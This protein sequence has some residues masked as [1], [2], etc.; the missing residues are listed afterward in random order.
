M[1]PRPA[2][3]H[4]NRR[5]RARR[6]LAIPVPRVRAGGQSSHSLRDSRP[7][8]NVTSPPL[9]ISALIRWCAGRERS[10]DWGNVST[11]GDPSAAQP[12]PPG[13]AELLRQNGS[14]GER[15]PAQLSPIA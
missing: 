12:L 15:L 10:A 11:V 4:R 3:P 1:L 8:V 2:T 6:A 13:A 14:L 7:A 9:P 5:D